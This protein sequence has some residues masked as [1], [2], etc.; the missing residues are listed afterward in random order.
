MPFR[1]A[2][3]L[4]ASVILIGLASW[5]RFSDL[6]EVQN[7]VAV[8]RPDITE[9]EYGPI[10]NDFVE[11]GATTTIPFSGPVN[12]TDLI[13]RQLILDYISMAANGQATEATIENLANQ[14]VESIPMIGQSPVLTLEDIKSV[15]DSKTNS[16]NYANAMLEI[17]R[18]LARQITRSQGSNTDLGTLNASL[19]PFALSIGR[20]YTLAS[21]KLKD[22]SVPKSIAPTHLQLINNYLSSAHA[23]KSLSEAEQDSTSAFAGL[24]VLSENI[25]KER[26]LLDRISQILTANGI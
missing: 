20:A 16:Q 14:Y 17:H 13:S 25:E 4:S 15:S 18:N 11:P 19:Y 6:T 1:L 7:I 23:M 21:L 2:L 10:L 5:Q 9:E 22:L 24:V 12:N 26:V 3:A 8:E